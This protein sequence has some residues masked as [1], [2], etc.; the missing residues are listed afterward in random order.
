MTAKKEKA[1]RVHWQKFVEKYF[2]FCREKFGLN[3]IF[4]GSSPRDLAGIYDGLKIN[5]EAEGIEWG[6]E[7]ATAG[8]GL[9]LQIAYD[10]KWTQE[11][12][13]LFI[14]NR[15]KDKIFFKMKKMSNGQQPAN[16]KARVQ[17]EF[18]RRHGRG[19]S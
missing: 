17:A 3:P 7:S 12:F 9:F 18:E 15:H 13:M 8:L 1:I 6:L 19:K 10:D 11:N 4:D 5:V 16:L 14:L 2:E